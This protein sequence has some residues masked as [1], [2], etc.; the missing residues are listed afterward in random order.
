MAFTHTIKEEVLT[1]DGAVSG[2]FAYSTEAQTT[3]SVSVPAASTD[4]QVLV[5]IDVS[6]VKS[7][8]L[9]SDKDLTVETNSPSAPTNTISLKANKPYIWH[10]DEYSTFKLTA[11]VTS[12]YLTNAGAAAAT[13][14]MRVLFDPT[15]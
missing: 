4:L 12:L 3:L 11:D 2:Q 1:G 15:P 14:E 7:F 5:N 8:Y 6:Q 9:L 10:T 13:L